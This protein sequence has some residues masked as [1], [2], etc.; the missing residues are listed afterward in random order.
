M[1]L[2]DSSHWPGGRSGRRVGGDQAER[3]DLVVRDPPQAQRPL[4]SRGVQRYATCGHERLT[5]SA[6]VGSISPV[7]LKLALAL[8]SFG[9]AAGLGLI[10]IL[11]DDAVAVSHGDGLAH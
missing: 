8:S 2:A 4:R 1:A 6:P 5:A 10:D 11:A 3:P 7:S 9:D